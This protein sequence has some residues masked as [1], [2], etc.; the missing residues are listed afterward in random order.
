MVRTS[1]RARRWF[2]EDSKVKGGGLCGG[3]GL[4]GGGYGGYGMV[5]VKVKCWKRG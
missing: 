2:R 1:I 3:R 5:G 4:G